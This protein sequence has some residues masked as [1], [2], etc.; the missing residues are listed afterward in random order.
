MTGRLA[1]GCLAVLAASV[2]TP[3]AP[4][5]DGALLFVEDVDEAPYRID[6]YLTQLR[7]GGHFEGLRGIAFGHL[8][9]C[10]GHPPGL[11]AQVLRD[12]FRDAPFPVA[13][14]VQAGHGALN[15]TLPLGRPA[16][17]TLDDGLVGGAGTLQVL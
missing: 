10:D 9:D 13:T 5:T 17:L 7:Q 4:D 15:L 12:L 3:W 14:G 6:R 8:R 1:G 16:A 11:L 2:G